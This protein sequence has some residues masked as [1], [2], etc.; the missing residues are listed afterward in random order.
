MQLSQ[1]AWTVLSMVIRFCGISILGGVSNVCCQDWISSSDQNSPRSTHFNDFRD[2]RCSAIEE[3]HIWA[4]SV[5]RLAFVIMH[6][7]LRFT[8]CL[9]KF[10]CELITPAVDVVAMDVVRSRL[11]PI[12]RLTE[13]YK[14]V[15]KKWAQTRIY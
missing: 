5:H 3:G 1:A 7:F 13:V 12:W 4:A 11:S 14:A 2:V 8:S 6:F 9:F 15:I 10:L